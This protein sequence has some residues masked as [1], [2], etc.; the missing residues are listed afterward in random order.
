M[1]FS[2]WL[3]KSVFHFCFSGD[4]L[5][6]GQLNFSSLNNKNNFFMLAGVSREKL[7]TGQALSISAR[8]ISKQF[9][10]PKGKTPEKDLYMA[11]QVFADLT[12][13][14]DFEE[15]SAQE[16]QD[17]KWVMVMMTSPWTA[18]SIFM[19]VWQRK[20]WRTWMWVFSLCDQCWVSK[21]H[22]SI[23]NRPLTLCCQKDAEDGLCSQK[24]DNYSPPTVVQ[25]TDCTS[26]PSLYDAMWCLYL[27][28]F[29]L[30]CSTIKYHLA[31][32]TMTTTWDFDLH[33]Y[34]LVP[35]DW[36]I[37]TEMQDV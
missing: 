3:G 7:C 5:V 30:W 25:N 8:A 17:R 29:D 10:I 22:W 13:E 12:K 11:A 32:D 23:F 16:S 20:M 33:K 6:A 4:K 24:F 9:D 28:E 1:L 34:E 35:L 15:Q 31:I 27:I 14:L 21:V 19:M 37:T 36:R 2:H 26:P 18:G